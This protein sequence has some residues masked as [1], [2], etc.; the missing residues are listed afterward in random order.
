MAAFY[1]T[2][3][4]KT[5]NEPRYRS[6]KPLRVGVDS[7]DPASFQPV[8]PGVPPPSRGAALC[9]VCGGMLSF[10]REPDSVQTDEDTSDPALVEL[11]KLGADETLIEARDHSRGVLLLTNRRVVLLPH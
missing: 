11:F 7:L 4:C 2:A 9:H 8:A 5:C 1:F 6:I 10:I 3:V